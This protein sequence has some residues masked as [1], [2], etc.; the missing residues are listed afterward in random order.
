MALGVTHGVWLGWEV[1]RLL[2]DGSGGG[3]PGALETDDTTIGGE[4]LV[5]LPLPVHH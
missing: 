4:N 1:I 5:G 2:A 3:C